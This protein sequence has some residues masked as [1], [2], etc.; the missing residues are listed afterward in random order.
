MSYCKSEKLYSEINYGLLGIQHRT[1]NFYFLT[2]KHVNMLL[3]SIPVSDVLHAPLSYL[4]NRCNYLPFRLRAL[5][6]RSVM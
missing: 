4:S 2:T 6:C 5:I 1:I 3:P